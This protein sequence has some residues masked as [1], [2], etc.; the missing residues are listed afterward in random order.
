M[1]LEV[2]HRCAEVDSSEQFSCVLRNMS[3]VLASSNLHSG[4]TSKTMQ[5]YG[6]GLEWGGPEAVKVVRIA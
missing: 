1:L 2:G 6:L 3:L 4:Q 5:P